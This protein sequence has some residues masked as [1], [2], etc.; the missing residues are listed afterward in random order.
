MLGQ[1]E[2]ACFAAMKEVEVRVRSLAGLSDDWYGT[3]LMRKAFNAGGALRDSSLEE[4]EANSRADLFAGAIGSLKNPPSHRT[5]SYSNPT[6]ASEVIMLA[7]MLMRSLDA[8]EK[9]LGLGPVAT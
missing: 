7:D 6:E 9:K 8:I 2:T 1:Y 5:V 3:K 4:G